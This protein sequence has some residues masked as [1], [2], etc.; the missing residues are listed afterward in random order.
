MEDP[1]IDGALDAEATGLKDL[2]PAVVFAEDICLKLLD[3]VVP[4]D[5]RKVFEQQCANALALVGVGI[6]LVLIVAVVV[7]IVL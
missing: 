5:G 2:E 4:G 6:L 7:V 3:A 1:S